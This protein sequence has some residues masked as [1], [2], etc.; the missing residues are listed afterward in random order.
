LTFQFYRFRFYFRALSAVYFPEGKSSN[1]LRGSFGKWLCDTVPAKVYSR[2]FEPGKT[3]GK[4]PS[5]LSDWPRPFVFRASHLDGQ[6]IA[7]G[8]KFHFDL[9]TFDLQEAVLAPF[10]SIFPRIASDGLG[11]GRGRA[12]M[13]GAAQLD[14][15]D[16]AT[17]V[18][19]EAG[20]PC[21]IALDPGPQ[22]V[23]RVRLRFETP[24]ELKRNGKVCEHPEFPVLFGRLRDRISNLAALYGTGPIS[25]DFSG[26]G[27]RASGVKLNHCELRWEHLE[28]RSA[29]TGQVHP[30]GGFMGI[31]EYEGALSEFMPWLSAARWVGV[32]RQTVWGKG[33]VRVL[34]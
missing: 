8:A 10:R 9:H 19:D 24:T 29:R 20:A 28:R 6:T 26:M 18:E 12:I 31:A 4:A 15:D 7:P 32:G 17:P 11:P 1:V 21:T 30:L 27:E 5:G 13:E 23:A 3:L 25:I 2:L 34:S 33:D 16:H 22:A 14:L